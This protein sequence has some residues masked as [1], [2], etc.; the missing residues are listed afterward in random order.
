MVDQYT[1]SNLDNISLEGILSMFKIGNFY[2]IKTETLSVEGCV[3]VIEDSEC[4]SDGECQGSKIVTVTFDNGK[5]GFDFSI[6]QDACNTGW[7]YFNDVNGYNLKWGGT[8]EVIDYV[9]KLDKPV[10][11]LLDYEK[12]SEEADDEVDEEEIEYN[13]LR[14]KSIELFYLL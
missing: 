13:R 5:G 12:T 8:Y 1:N 4:Q 10:D 2:Q 3:I 6:S 11:F 14:L 9:K 7:W